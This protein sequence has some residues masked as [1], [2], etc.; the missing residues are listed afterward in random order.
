MHVSHLNLRQ[1]VSAFVIALC[2]GLSAQASENERAAENES[3]WSALKKP[4]AII[5]FRHATAPGG[6]DPAGYVLNDCR[7]QR[8]L[9]DEGR[10][11]ARRIGER[12][13]EQGVKVE[14]VLTSQWCRTRET[15][16]LAFPGLPKDAPAFN[17]FFNDRGTEAAQT[18]AA[19]KQL[20]TWRGGGVLV[21][22]THQVNIT[23][24]TGI[25]PASG[26]GV[27]L[28]KRGRELAVVARL[29]P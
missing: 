22:V 7:T 27:I 21:V 20:L 28:Q 26:E 9:D 16:Q 5:L 23:A 15:A 8:N 14:A 19:R 11:Q 24:L 12:F 17:S 18:A 2:C 6:G 10:A 1:L 13:R 4:G 3:A 25:S 29:A